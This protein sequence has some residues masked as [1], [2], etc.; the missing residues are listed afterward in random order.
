M[1][2]HARRLR[3]VDDLKIAAPLVVLAIVGT[4][5]NLT[6]FNTISFLFGSIFAIMALKLLGLRWGVLIAAIGGSVTIVLW[7]H[8]YAA[9]IFTLEVLFVGLLTR[10]S[11]QL[12][13]ADALFWTVLGFG[14]VLLTYSGA[15]GLSLGT[16]AFVGMK[17]ALNGVFNA[18]VA[19]LALAALRAM[20]PAARTR[21]PPV[22]VNPLLFHMAAFVTILS[23]AVL[24][25]AESRA[26]FNQTHTQLSVVM[27]TVGRWAVAQVQQG[28]GPENLQSALEDELGTLLMFPDA[29]F[30]AGTDIAVSVVEDTGPARD[31]FG[32]SVS[33][34]DDGGLIESSGGLLIWEPQDPTA[35]LQRAR[36]SRYV[37]DVPI[38]HQGDIRS[39]RVEFSAAPMID[40]LE[41]AGRRKLLLLFGTSAFG[42]AL[43]FWLIGALT[44]P[45]TRMASTSSGIS[46]AIIQ[47]RPFG[48]FSRSGIAEYDI[49]STTL[50]EMSRSLAVAFNDVETMTQKLE[51]RVRDRTAQLHLMSQVVR[52]TDNMVVITDVSG[53]V[54]WVNEAFERFTGYNLDEIAGKTP[55]EMLQRHP[56]PPDLA[57]HMRTCIANGLSFHVELQNQSKGGQVYW[58]EIRCNPVHEPDGTLTGFIAIQVDVTERHNAR[59][60]LETSLERLNLAT[61]VGQL[62]VWGY[63]TRSRQIDWNARNFDLHGLSG[64][65][66]HDLA[67]DWAAL[68][69]PDDLKIITSI[70]AGDLEQRGE[71]FS[72]EYKI[73]HPVRGT[74]VMA[75]MARC[76]FEDGVV[77]RVIG[78]TRDVTEE[79]RASENLR[80]TAKHTAA[81]LNNVMDAIIAIDQSGKITSYN[82]AAERIFGYPPDQIIGQDVN[83]LMA[84]VHAQHH[85][86]FIRSYLTSGQRK[87]MGRI[88]EF[89]ALRRTGEEFP[90]ELAVSEIIDGDERFFI[91]II[92]DVTERMQL[93][94]RLRQA[95]KLEAVGQLTGGIA[96]DFNNLLTVILGNSETLVDELGGREDLR[97]LAE[98]IAT[99]AERGA[100]LTSRL[101]AFSRRQPLK[102]EKLDINGLLSDMEPLLRRAIGGN[103]AVTV[104]PTQG[105]WIAEVDASQL[106]AAILNLALNARDAMPDGGHLT[107]ET[108]NA[109][110]DDKFPSI[111]EKVQ[112]GQYVVLTVAD[113][114]TGMSPDVMERAFEPFFTTKDVGKG[115]GLGLSMVFG[116]VKQSGGH[117]RLTSAPGQGTEAL[118]YFP[119][120]EQQ[121]SQTEDKASAQKPEPG[122]ERILVVEDDPLVRQHVVSQLKSLGYDVIE[123]ENGSAAIAILGQRSDIDLLF[124]DVIMPGGMTGKDVADR[125]RRMHPHIKVLFTTGYA[126]TSIVHEGRLDE[127]VE[128]LGKPYRRG[129]LA[130]K[131]RKVLD[132]R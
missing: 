25:V 4:F 117:I 21:I 47:K 67:Q 127:D 95:Q 118:L 113:T 60:E 98:M 17:Q 94:A 13:L 27:S 28:G 65:G 109:V 112:A 49:L 16:A 46:A 33:F 128:L 40:T 19:G 56:P 23:A 35:A 105:L 45:L 123:A 41:A 79:R 74:R 8:P 34:G 15:L 54:T 7:G 131:L 92:R 132:S 110:L 53:K 115:S 72:F 119:R 116:F 93:E 5:A 9:L 70:F 64:H 96:H 99:T 97:N 6:L 76:I 101:L 37:L 87:V 130:A 121:S 90:I 84:P 44:T 71:N 86:G 111:G 69:D 91:G 22:S 26:M 129:T 1:T 104:T 3:V 89:T 103:I 114:G 82:R 77:V 39:L 36:A 80:R 55:G 124:T 14:L 126:E 75:A 78:V 120:A 102:P 52:Q 29:T 31:I 24:V 61:E 83:I 108:S 58:V 42:L 62:G 81:I 125:A 107:I 20:V 38:T 122:A 48:K 85:G 32:A 66:V 51:E 68:V 100:Q 50:D 43:S 30:D 63:G 106:E 10:K 59:L 73:S 11:D 88:S 12:A 2:A 18:V 57:E